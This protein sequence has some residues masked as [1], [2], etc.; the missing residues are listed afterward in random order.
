MRTTKK[1]IKYRLA[2][3]EGYLEG[4]SAIVAKGKLTVEDRNYCRERIR[5]WEG[6]TEAYREMLNEN[7]ISY[8]EDYLRCADERINSIASL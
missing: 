4:Y 6:Y 2:K 1:D 7:I 8:V 3:A 5:W